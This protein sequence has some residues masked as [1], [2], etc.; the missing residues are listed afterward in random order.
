MKKI[1]ALIN[2]LKNKN[3]ARKQ[4]QKKKSQNTILLQNEQCWIVIIMLIPTTDLTKII[5]ELYW[6]DG[7]KRV[8]KENE[9][10]IYVT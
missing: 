2:Q 8:E 7:G 4:K 9:T 5:I 3:R 1:E 6:K 10:L